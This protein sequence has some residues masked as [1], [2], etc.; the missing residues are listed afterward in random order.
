[1]L[2]VWMIPI[3]GAQA[4]AG[5]AFTGFVARC[6][7]A[8]ISEYLVVAEV[9]TGGGA[10]LTFNSEIGGTNVTG[11]AV[12]WTTANAS[13]AKVAGAAVTA[14]NVFHEGDLIDIEVA[15]GTAGTGGLATYVIEYE[16]RL[17][18]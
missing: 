10:S 15:L 12:V 17:G 13:G 4:G 6:H 14:A 3:S 18:V 8:I 2:D 7:G 9:L 16:R 11:S 1:V 5:N